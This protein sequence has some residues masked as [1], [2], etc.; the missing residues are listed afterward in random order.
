MVLTVKFCKCVTVL[1]WK[2]NGWMVG[3][4]AGTGKGGDSIWGN[5]FEDEYREALKVSSFLAFLEF[6]FLP[7][8]L[9]S[10][11]GHLASLMSP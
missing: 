9:G 11:L 5:K 2:F 10:L 4:C 1:M 7:P 6:T 3:L 8:L